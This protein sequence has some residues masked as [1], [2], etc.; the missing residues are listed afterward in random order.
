MAANPIPKKSLDR[1]TAEAFELNPLESAELKAVGRKSNNTEMMLSLSKEDQDKV[2]AFIF[3][4]G[5]GEN[6][7]G[8]LR[9]KRG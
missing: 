8:E 3:G 6:P 7:L 9:K 5:S 1:R 4:G 2:K